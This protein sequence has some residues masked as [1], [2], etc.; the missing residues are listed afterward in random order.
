[1]QTEGYFLFLFLSFF[2]KI[3]LKQ[4]NIPFKFNIY[5]QV[6][7]LNLTLMCKYPSNLKLM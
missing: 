6:S 3:L 4:T 1:M 5:V 2:T 7:P